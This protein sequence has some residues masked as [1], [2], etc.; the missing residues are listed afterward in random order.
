MNY[1]NCAQRESQLPEELTAPGELFM[2]KHRE[3]AIILASI[4]PLFWET[5]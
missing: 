3:R 4:T 2:P 1:D 5:G